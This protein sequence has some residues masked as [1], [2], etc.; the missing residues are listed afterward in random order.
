[1]L[2][3]F[4]VDS[5]SG[6]LIDLLSTQPHYQILR[7]YS[8]LEVYFLPELSAYLKIGE[9][10]KNSNLGWERKVLEWL[11]GKIN[12]PAILDF[13]IVDEREY[14]LISE[15]SGQTYSDKLAVFNKPNDI[16][17]LAELVAIHIRRIHDLPIEDCD[18]DQR[19]TAK[20]KKA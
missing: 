5:M 19:L 13:E 1:M 17:R 9:I 4:F 12:V 6:S 7:E 10:G 14:L 2:F 11:S 3:S 8:R 20:I 16:E 18:L 15:I